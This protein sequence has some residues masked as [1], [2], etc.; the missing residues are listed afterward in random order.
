MGEQASSLPNLGDGVLKA[1]R[2][3][4]KRGSLAPLLPRPNDG[5]QELAKEK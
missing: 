2:N 3:N 5:T 4:K 1:T